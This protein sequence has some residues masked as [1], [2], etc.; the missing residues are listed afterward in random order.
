ML[1]KD[2]EEAAHL[3]R[4]FLAGNKVMLQLEDFPSFDDVTN[5][6]QNA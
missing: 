6:F 5:N 4:R 2:R 3:C 1:Y